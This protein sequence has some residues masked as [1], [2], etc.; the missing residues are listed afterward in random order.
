[1]EP[2][3]IHELKVWSKF[4]PSLW[5]GNKKFEVRKDDRD[6]KPGDLLRLREWDK[7]AEAYGPNEIIARITCK[8]NGGQFG[9]EEGYCVLS[10]STIELIGPDRPEDLEW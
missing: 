10:I 7:D 3:K 4:F 5:N 8:L 2:T 6:F 1:M 9:I